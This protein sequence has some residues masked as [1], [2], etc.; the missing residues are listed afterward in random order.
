[1]Q[2]EKDAHKMSFAS[3]E[4]AQGAS[5]SETCLRP[6]SGR[7]KY[8][9]FREAVR[10]FLEEDQE[11]SVH[12]EWQAVPAVLSCGEGS[13][14]ESSRRA[15]GSSGFGT[16]GN[17]GPGA[18]G[19]SGSNWNN[20]AGGGNN[21][22]N[23]AADLPEDFLE[24][25]QEKGPFYEFMTISV[26]RLYFAYM[27]EG[28]DATLRDLEKITR[29]EHR[30]ARRTR[31]IDYEARLNEDGVRLYNKLR[32]LRSRCAAKKQVPPY[33]VF[34]NRS[35]YEMCCRQP[36]TMDELRAIYGVGEKN[37]GEYGEVFL[38]EIAK[39]TGGVMMQMMKVP[40][41]AE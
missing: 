33:F 5:S 39:Y 24:L 32:E 12:A 26:S 21:A 11:W 6:Q 23:T 19:S 37:S 9:V 14:A 8:E 25:E 34:M 20:I 40:A 35:L 10:E 29:R 3:L 18:A 22:A 4:A 1:M 2:Y 31:G 41:R 28:W 27:E 36:A 7:C 13:V 17:G 16:A 30:G 38:E 15:A